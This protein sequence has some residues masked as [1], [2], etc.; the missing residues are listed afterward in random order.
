MHNIPFFRQFLS[1]DYI[2]SAQTDI[3]AGKPVSGE[4]LLGAIEQSIQQQLPDCVRDI[5][6]RALVPAVKT[7]GRPMK[8]GALLDFALEKVDGRYPAL[9]RFEQRKKDRLLKTGKGVSKGDYSPSLRAYDRLLRH[10]KDAF[11]PMTPE[12]LRNQHSAWRN[13]R[14]HASD[15]HIDSEDFEAEIESRFPIPQ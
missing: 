2:L 15:N 12:A 5:V 1:I 11:G 14:Y 7:R 9:L 6:R 8:F 13:G 4:T 3:K 10:M